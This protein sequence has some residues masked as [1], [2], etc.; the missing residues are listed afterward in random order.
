[1]IVAEHSSE[2]LTPF[3][4]AVEIAFGAEGLQ[5]IAPL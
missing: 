5:A 4:W 1:M 2:S 3:N